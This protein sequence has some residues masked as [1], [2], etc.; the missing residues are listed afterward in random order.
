[1][2]RPAY[3]VVT[4]L[5]LV[6]SLAGAAMLLYP[7]LADWWNGIHQSQAIADYDK[8]VAQLDT[9][10]ADDMLAK[11]E[12]YNARLAASGALW[13]MNDEEMREY[14]GL[15]NV[16]GTGLMAYLD[17]PKIGVTLPI[18]HGTSN[19]VLVQAIGHIA[20]TSL[21][22]G[23]EGTHCSV[24]GHR[25]LPNAKLFTD[26]NKLE[27][28]DLFVVTVLDRVLTYEVDQIRVVLPTEIDDLTIDPD[29][30]YM[31][32]VTCT[33]YGVNSH[34]LLIRGHRV[35]NLPGTLKIVA[36]AVQVRSYLVAAALAIPAVALFLVAIYVGTEK[37]MRHRRALRAVRESLHRH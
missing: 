32:L 33:P 15:L 13:R 11:A 25:G 3:N 36:D 1:M 4:V 22:V 29:K 31:T 16:G 27:T 28:G 2:R 30:D 24:S 17:I 37:S 14:N 20:G 18:Y 35:D 10:E 8:A 34:R 5:L 9:S 21:P 7:V 23:G 26:I 12:E 6:A 19:D